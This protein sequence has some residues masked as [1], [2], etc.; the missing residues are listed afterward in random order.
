MLDEIFGLIVV[1]NLELVQSRRGQCCRHSRP[2]R[3]RW[4]TGALCPERRSK[5]RR[6]IIEGVNVRGDDQRA[7]MLLRL[8][9]S[10]LAGCS[11]CSLLRA[12]S[13]DVLHCH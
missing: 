9:D 12:L 8:A 7:W 4:G 5:F 3:G 13:V 1:V 11:P 10:Q 2:G 6:Q